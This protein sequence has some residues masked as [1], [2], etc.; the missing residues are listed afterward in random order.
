[1]MPRENEK[2]PTFIME[3]VESTMLKCLFM[4]QRKQV[5]KS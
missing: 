3:L 5:L 1:M 4:K 2:A